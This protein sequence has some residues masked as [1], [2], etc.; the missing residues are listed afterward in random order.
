M[1]ST[2]RKFPVREPEILFYSNERKEEEFCVNLP[3]GHP[4]KRVKLAEELEG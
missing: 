2:K 4:V 1:M 3:P